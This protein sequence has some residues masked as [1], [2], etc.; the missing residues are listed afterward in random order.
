MTVEETKRAYVQPT[1][2]PPG[3]ATPGGF[4]F[5]RLYYRSR[6]W[7]SG[8]DFLFFIG[9]TNHDRRGNKTRIC[10]TNSEAPRRCDSRG[11]SLLAV[12]VGHRF[13]SSHLQM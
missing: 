9:Y 11:A 3:A 13:P 4:I 6:K 1:A 8:I 12:T 5:D 10:P 2:K 7:K